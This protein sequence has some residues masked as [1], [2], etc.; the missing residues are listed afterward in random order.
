MTTEEQ[1]LMHRVRSAFTFAS[2]KSGLSETY[3]RCHDH[4]IMT[5]IQEIEN[6][7]E[8]LP[9][10]KLVEFRNW[11]S[12]FDDDRWDEQ[13]EQDVHTGKLDKLAEEALRDFDSKRC[14]EL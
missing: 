10:E 7:L 9:K 8:S 12:Q 5:T 2:R 4:T 6:A 11:Y 13:F 1:T 14:T 3:E